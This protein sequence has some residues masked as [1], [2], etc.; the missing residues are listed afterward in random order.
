M[1]IKAMS[2]VWDCSRQDGTNLNAMLALADWS[3]E[4]G[5]CWYS[6]ARLGQRVRRNERSVTRIMGAL[7][8]SG[9]LFAPPE[10]GAGKKTLKFVCIGMSQEAIQDVLERRFE[11]TPMEALIEAK[12]ILGRQKPVINDGLIQEKP[13]KNDGF[14]QEKPDNHDG[15]P[16]VIK[17]DTDDGF[18]IQAQQK[19][20]SGDGLIQGKPDKNDGFIG[21]K[22]DTAMSGDPSVIVVVVPEEE[23]TTTTKT[24][25]WEKTGAAVTAILSWLGFVG[26]CGKEPLTAETALAWAFWLQL[27]RPRLTQQG[28]D[29]LAITIAAWRRGQTQPPADCQRLAKA[30]L[31]MNDQERRL[32][33]TAAAQPLLELQAA[34]PQEL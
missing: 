21:K 10:R 33:L 8:E 9:E 23:K 22:P 32:T 4:D 26:D 19:P 17:P 30:W 13:D 29:P 34:M 1:S 6:N 25:A 28:K 15:F 5:I 31:N 2:R 12:R 27:H 7:R 3:D 20:D 16:D 11:L 14:V 24:G 18:P